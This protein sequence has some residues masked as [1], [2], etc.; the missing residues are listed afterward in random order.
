M[1]QVQ[2]R[3]G[4]MQKLLSWCRKSHGEYWLLFLVLCNLQDFRLFLTPIESHENLYGD[5]CSL[6][7]KQS[8]A[9]LKLLAEM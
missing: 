5:V 9:E 2:M 3:G 6:V 7:H 8:V 4:R 1:A